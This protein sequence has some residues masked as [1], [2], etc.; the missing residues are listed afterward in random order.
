MGPVRRIRLESERFGT[1]VVTQH[2]EAAGAPLDAL[3]GVSLSESTA[4][5]VP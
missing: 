4:W 2:G 3:V 5:V 1:L